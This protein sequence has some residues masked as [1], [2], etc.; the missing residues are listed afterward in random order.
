MENHSRKIVDYIQELSHKIIDHYKD[1]EYHIEVEYTGSIQMKTIRFNANYT[2]KELENILPIVFE[3]GAI[4]AGK[5]LNLMIQQFEQ[6][7][8]KGQT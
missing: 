7:I 4:R 6:G 8:K 3:R 2:L 1:E 5:K